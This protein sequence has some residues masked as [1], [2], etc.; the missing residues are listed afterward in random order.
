M[1]QTS[2]RLL[3]HQATKVNIHEK[4]TYFIGYFRLKIITLVFWNENQMVLSSP[5][6]PCTLFEFLRTLHA[7][8]FIGALRPNH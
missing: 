7:Q 1:I 5:K 4:F 3:I 6:C 8:I 2:I